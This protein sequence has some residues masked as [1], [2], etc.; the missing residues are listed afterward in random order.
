MDGLS[1]GD[2]GRINVAGAMHVARALGP[3]HALS[4]VTHGNASF[5]QGQ[6]LETAILDAVIQ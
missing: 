6:L 3:G 4:S 2:S 5:S 1:F